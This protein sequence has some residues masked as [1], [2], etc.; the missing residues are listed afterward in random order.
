LRA[1]RQREQFQPIR[2]REG[3]DV[4]LLR[5]SV[6]DLAIATNGSAAAL[7]SDPT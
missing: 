6:P 2:V 4:P 7:K 3:E 1:E 5:P